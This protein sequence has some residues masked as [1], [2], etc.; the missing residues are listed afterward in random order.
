MEQSP[1]PGGLARYPIKTVILVAFGMLLLQGISEI[2]KN[3]ALLTGHR[4]V[5][6]SGTAQAAERADAL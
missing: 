5:D 4:R 3:A 6:E 1:N 2:I